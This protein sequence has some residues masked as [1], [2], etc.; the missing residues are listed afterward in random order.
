[1]KL[2]DVSSKLFKTI[3]VGICLIEIETM[4]VI[5][6]NSAFAKWFPDAAQGAAFKALSKDEL[7]TLQT[8]RMVETRTKVRA[9][10]LVI[11]MRAHEAE[12]EGKNL[13]VIEC[14]NIS[15]L[16]ETEAM[17]D[18]YASMVDRR[19]REL[20]REKTQ[21]EKLLL[22][23]MPHSV[24]EEYTTFG[25]VAPKLYEPVSVI[26]LDFVGFTQMAAAAD[27]NV[28]V[29][30]L[31]DIFTAFDRIAELHGAERI[32]TIGDC[33]MAVVGLPHPNAD[34]AISAAR[35]A[36]KMIRYLNRRN[37]THEHKWRARIGIAAGSV[38]GSVVGVQKYIFDVFG[39]AVNLAARLQ[40][41]SKPMEIT[42]CS[43]VA[44][45]I[46]GD[47]RIVDTRQETLNGFGEIT[48]SVIKEAPIEH[49]V[50]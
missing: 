23:L 33:Y 2:Q 36:S 43:T 25:S 7:Q 19:T 32:K 31:N 21:V 8:G 4:T 15:R 12:F 38:V 20:E 42:A 6:M 14:Q 46:N 18:S 9:R 39:P 1:M 5:S 24:Y 30:E 50:A 26:M 48:V 44:D 11:E 13:L 22:N 34:H 37:E 29:S 27:P 41:L 10:T 49:F 45:E 17:I 28:T 3:G 47:L 35:C 40:T 16:R